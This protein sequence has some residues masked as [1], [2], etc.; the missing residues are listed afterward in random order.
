MKMLKDFF[1]RPSGTGSKLNIYMFEPS[2]IRHAL[3]LVLHEPSYAI[4]RTRIIIDQLLH[5]NDPWLTR[6]AISF[7]DGYLRSDMCGFEFGSGRSTRWLARRMARLISI[8]DDPSWFQR[9]RRDVEN[10][11]VDYR[12]A[13]TAA[14][15]REYV[16][17]LLAFPDATFDL[18]LIDGS[19][20]DRCISAAAT[21]IKPGGI[22]VLDNAD[23]IRDVQPLQQFDK[24][25]TNNGVWRTDIYTRL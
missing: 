15:C 20:R 21:K 12:F 25:S 16:S 6:E 1:T 2:R 8:E 24:Y 3:H 18:I 17:Q 13:S 14:G 10:L 4:A 19:C 5:P 23:E 11:N 9:V 7:F 22:V